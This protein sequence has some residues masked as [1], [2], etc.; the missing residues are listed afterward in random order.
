MQTFEYRARDST[1]KLHQGEV[2]AENLISARKK[3][4]SNGFIAIQ[5]KSGRKFDPIK[6]ISSEFRNFTHKVSIEDLIMFS[7][8]MQIVYS[9]GIPILH[10]MKLL[11]E[12]TANP[13]LK[14]AIAEMAADIGDGSTFFSAL[15]RHQHIFDPV[16]IN[17]VRI[18]EASGQLQTMLERASHLI[19]KRSEQRE[20]VKSATFYPKMVFVF[21]AM[22]LFVVVYVVLPKLKTFFTGLGGEL[23]LI[24]RIVMET[25]DAFVAYWYLVVAIVGGGYYGFAKL[26]SNPVSRLWYDQTLLK[27]PVI[28][29][30]LLQ[31]EINTFCVLLEV[32]LES[33]VPIL[34]A[35]QYVAKS[36]TNKVVEADVIACHAIIEKGGSLAN[37]LESSKAF[38]KLVA[39]LLS[40]GEE[41]GSLPKVLNQISGF[42]K[43][44]VD[45]KLNNLSKLI[46]PI[47]LFF[48]FGIVLVIALAVFMP[49]WK[50]SSA[51]K[52]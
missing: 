42:Y 13:V 50:M 18:G 11:H 47:L 34:E 41:G 3:V 29:V 4:A 1:G 33:G 6:I 23:P 5:I 17:L 40:I 32:M 30:L 35:F 51:L 12:Q 15:E 20:K 48:I 44:Q 26:K 9:V 31:I 28:G 39:G 52:K 8:Q 22:V 16:Y 10:G 37:G 21:F 45:Y 14:K 24:T 19:E 38:P 25:S 7:R 49:M 36:L 27:I 46:E 43:V 2:A